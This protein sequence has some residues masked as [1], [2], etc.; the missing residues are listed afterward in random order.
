MTTLMTGLNV[1]KS[2]AKRIVNERKVR[3]KEMKS[4][5]W[6]TVKIEECSFRV[7]DKILKN[8]RR[9]YD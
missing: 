2:S 3:E 6:P 9:K 4:K 5:D 1:Y 8:Q 7:M